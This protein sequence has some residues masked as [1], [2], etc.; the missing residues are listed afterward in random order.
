MYF[1]VNSSVLIS[2][3]NVRHRL[4]VGPLNSLLVS[5]VDELNDMMNYSCHVVSAGPPSS[6]KFP[7]SAV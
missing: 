4:S 1:H 6:T 2:R 7:G 5:D 3:E